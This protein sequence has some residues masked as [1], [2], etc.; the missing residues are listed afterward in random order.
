MADGRKFIISRGE[1]VGT[2][3]YK[4]NEN[5][6]S[7]D[8]IETFFEKYNEG[9]EPEV[10]KASILQQFS[11]NVDNFDESDDVFFPLAHCL[12]EVCALDKEL[13]AFVRERIESGANLEVLKELDAN[14]DFLK[15]RKAMLDKFLVKISV[16]RDKPKA[17]KKPPVRVES[18]Y[19]AGSCLVFQYPDG[20]YGGVVTIET[21]FF[22]TKGNIALALTNIRAKAKPLF[23]DFERAN[24]IGFEWEQVHGQAERYAA[25]KI[26]GKLYTGRMNRFGT[27]YNNKLERETL[28]E[29]LDYHFQII[30]AFPAFTQILCS[31]FRLN[32]ADCPQRFDNYYRNTTDSIS[33]QMLQELAVKLSTNF[34]SF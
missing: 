24:L 4:L 34:K 28:F 29:R 3:G 17:R 18:P 8:V 6:T 20:S 21:D 7:F 2:W 5:D 9:M 11:F 31:T 13:L 16:Q 33:S 22:S 12:W 26:D 23:E 14:D 27:F 10:I 15:E 32:I 1:Q 30:G 25:V 19:Q